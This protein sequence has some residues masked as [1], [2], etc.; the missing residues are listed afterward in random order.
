MGLELPAVLHLPPENRP[1]HA[2]IS[3]AGGYAYISGQGPMDGDRPLLVGTVGNE[4]SLEQGAEAARL[5]CLSMLSLLRQELGDLDRVVRWVRAIGYVNCVPGWPSAP[6]VVNGFSDLIVDLW[7]DAGKHA[8]SAPGVT[9]LPLN[10]PV[11]VEA[12]VEIADQPDV[13]AGGLPADLSVG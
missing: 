2:P 10:V 3:Y 6:A 5:T 11:I 9:A 8:R 13:D 7:G 12:M 1:N 4:L